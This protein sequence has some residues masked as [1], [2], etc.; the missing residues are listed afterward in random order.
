MPF[1]VHSN[2]LPF[3]L[4]VMAKDFKEDYLYHAAALIQEVL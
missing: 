3:G 1:G 4:Q 2:G